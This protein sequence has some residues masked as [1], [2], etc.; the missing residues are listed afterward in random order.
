MPNNQIPTATKYFVWGLFF[1]NLYLFVHAAETDFFFPNYLKYAFAIPSLLTLIYFFIKNKEINTYNGFTGLIVNIFTIVSL[2]MVSIAPF[3]PRPNYP[4][5][6]FIQVIFT[7]RY[8]ILPYI[9]SLLMLRIKFEMDFFQYLFKIAKIFLPIAIIITAIINLFFIDTD[10]FTPWY[11]QIH[12][13]WIF[14][15]GFPLALFV[16]HLQKKNTTILFIIY[17]ILVLYFSAAYGRRGIALD[18]LGIILGYIFIL[19][20]NKDQ[21][22]KKYKK[23]LLPSFVIILLLIISFSYKITNLYIF[24]RGFDEDAIEESRGSVFDDFYS[25]FTSSFDW[26]FGRGINGDYVRRDTVYMSGKA[27]YIE[28]GFLQIILKGGLIYL[29]PMLFLLLSSFYRGFFQSKN[30]LTK[31]LGIFC[32]LQVI[33]MLWF[34][35]PDF[36]SKYILIWIAVSTCNNSEMRR[37]TNLQVSN[38][39]KIK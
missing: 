3:M 37:F 4:G 38:I 31:G 1:N 20:T 39:F 16:S 5:L 7:N 24:E 23:L 25:D 8:Y 35:V 34:G 10:F 19:L 12:M 13:I 21:F 17:F 29:I 14:E 27:D 36:S 18:Q 22:G 15:L 11:S 28:S 33:S 26:T 9:L 6:H 2:V 32:L 30:D